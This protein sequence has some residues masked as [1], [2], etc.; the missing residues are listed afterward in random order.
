MPELSSS[1]MPATLDLPENIM[2]SSSNRYQDVEPNEDD[3]APAMEDYTEG[4]SAADILDA[5]EIRARPRPR[6][7]SMS[8]WNDEE[9][10][11]LRLSR[12]HRAVVYRASR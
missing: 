6:R 1:T 3:G 9:D 7:D 8:A 10:G 11:K 4:A 5:I 12:L 2:A